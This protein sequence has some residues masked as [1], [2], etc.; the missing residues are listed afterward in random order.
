MSGAIG[1]RPNTDKQECGWSATA[2]CSPNFTLPSRA[3]QRVVEVGQ[4]TIRKEDTGVE[5]GLRHT[6][7]GRLSSKIVGV[8]PT[9]VEDKGVYFIGIVLWHEDS[10]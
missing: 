6:F 1:G 8:F 5:N 7:H 10:P 4:G 2:H 3:G 9:H